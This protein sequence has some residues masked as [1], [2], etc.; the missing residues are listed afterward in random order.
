MSDNGDGMHLAGLQVGW[1][2]IFGFVNTLLGGG[3]VAGFMRIW[4]KL[5]QQVIDQRRSDIDDLRKRTEVLE[6]KVDKANAEAAKARE[7]TAEVRMKA[8]AD[9]AEIRMSMQTTNTACQ[10]MAG[11]LRRI[12]PDNQVLR[13]ALDLMKQAA[14]PDLGFGEVGRRV[15]ALPSVMRDQRE[16][17]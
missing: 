1:G 15:A 4:P 2:A 12:D 9:T 7:E 5:R 17:E 13:Q 3:L 8:Q 11:E 16:K 6:A 10:L 14:A